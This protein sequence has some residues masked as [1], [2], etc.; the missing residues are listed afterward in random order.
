MQSDRRSSLSDRVHHRAQKT[1]P[2]RRCEAGLNSAIY[3]VH[4][5]LIILKDSAS[6]GSCTASIGVIL[7]LR[8]RAPETNLRVTSVIIQYSCIR[9]HEYID[10][11][12]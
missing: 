2:K 6:I 1:E 7:N 3:D 4:F 5:Y 12:K 9:N 10:L 8:R 11:F